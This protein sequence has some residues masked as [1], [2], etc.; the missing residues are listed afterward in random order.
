M[1]PKRYR[2]TICHDAEFPLGF[3]FE[4]HEPVCPRCGIGPLNCVE[5]TDVHLMVPDQR[6]GPI[7]GSKSRRYHI[8]CKPNAFNPH[9]VPMTIETQQIT[10]RACKLT[11]DYRRLK[12]AQSHGEAK[13][14]V[15]ILT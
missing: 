11:E 6:N 14:G 15:E 1:G 5:L 10:C 13:G 7:R 2:C 8:A 9:G 12:G 3:D 4:A